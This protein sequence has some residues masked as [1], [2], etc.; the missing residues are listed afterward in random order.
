MDE[1]LKQ[2]LI[3]RPADRG[4][5]VFGPGEELEPGEYFAH[6]A[7]IPGVGVARVTQAEALK[8]LGEKWPKCT[9]T[10]H[11]GGIQPASPRPAREVAKVGKGAKGA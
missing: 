10:W 7:L 5:K 11:P 1:I 4:H 8:A 2:L 3:R 9:F 6:P